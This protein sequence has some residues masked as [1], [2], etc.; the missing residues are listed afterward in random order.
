L[1]SFSIVLF[2][3]SVS[4]VSRIVALDEIDCDAHDSQKEIPPQGRVE[5]LL[6]HST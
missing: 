3:V 2:V 5:S 4:R 6:G 1:A